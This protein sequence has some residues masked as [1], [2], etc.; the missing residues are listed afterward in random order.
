VN[1]NFQKRVVDMWRGSILSRDGALQLLLLV[2]YIFDWARDLYRDDII[3][4][5]RVL[6]S[7]DNDAASIMYPD[8]DINSIRHIDI[9]DYPDDAGRDSDD[10]KSYMSARDSFMAIDSPAG[11]IRHAALIESKYCGVI[12]TRDNVQTLLKSIQPNKL[13]RLCRIVLAQMENAMLLEQKT[14]DKME[15]QWTGSCRMPT[16]HHPSETR[17]YTV[18]AYTTYISGEWNLIRELSTIALAEDAWSDVVT[19]SGLTRPSKTRTPLLPRQIDV[20]TLL[21][22]A[23]RLQAG[24][25]QQILH[26]A[27]VRNA[28]KIDVDFDQSPML[29][30]DDASFRN[31]VH[32]IYVQ[33]KR[34]SLEPQDPFMRVS[35]RLDQQHR[36]NNDVEPLEMFSEV[37]HVS[38]DGCVLVITSCSPAYRR[39]SKANVCAYLTENE[40]RLPTEGEV[41]SIIKNAFETRDVYHTT[42]DDG[43]LGISPLTTQE[44]SYKA[45][46]GLTKTYG[47]HSESFE[48]VH[49]ISKLGGQIPVTQ[50][51]SRAPNASGSQLYER[52]ISPWQDNR[53]IQKDRRER[54]FVLYKLL[55][56]EISFWRT[57][58]RDRKAQGM[59]CCECCA[60]V[61][62]IEDNGI[63]RTCNAVLQ[64]PNRYQWIKDC[65]LGKPPFTIKTLDEDGLG[66]RMSRSENH[67]LSLRQ[68]IW[69]GPHHGPTDD[70][71]DWAWNLDFYTELDE[72]FD[73]IAQLKTQWLQFKEFCSRYEQAGYWWRSKRKREEP[74]EDRDEEVRLE[75]GR[76]TS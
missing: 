11:V 24:S 44:K 46:W 33:M 72:P 27:I 50:G 28:V 26:G 39:T 47:V 31:I 70:E 21:N 23:K 73:N 54:M 65:L 15:E 2:D 52:N 1:A 66:E 9:M 35:S 45:L 25:T 61:S 29:V 42:R 67:D 18:I 48:F 49:L 8:S 32:A 76:F 71:G 34:G 64:D 74:L 5:L 6:A 36:L 53:Y 43:N 16:F 41:A 55:S 62:M 10:F 20:D 12:I 58:A 60:A 51:S 69:S 63:C 40:P 37:P 3:K 38:S 13:Q 56:R 59:S 19:A 57:S 4:E 14:L 7:G 22:T 75:E 68:Y 17:F 30:A